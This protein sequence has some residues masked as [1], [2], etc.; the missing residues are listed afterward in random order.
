MTNLLMNILL[1]LALPLNAEDCAMTAGKYGKSIQYQDMLCRI[2]VT[3]DRTD[4]RS[5]RSLTFNNEGAIQVFSNYKN[6]AKESNGARVF[7]LFPINKKKEI[8]NIIFRTGISWL[9]S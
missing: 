6:G 3:A 2:L 9:T 7:Y 4:D 5:F 8:S 1:H